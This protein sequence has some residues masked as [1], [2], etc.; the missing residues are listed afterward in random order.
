DAIRRVH[1]LRPK[2]DEGRAGPVPRFRQRR[3]HHGGRDAPG[4]RHRPTLRR[5]RRQRA[6]GRGLQRG[7]ADPEPL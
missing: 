5:Q 6:R 2:G 3:P 7:H 1:A 4:G